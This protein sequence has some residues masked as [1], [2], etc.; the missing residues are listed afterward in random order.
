MIKNIILIGNPNSGKSS[1][2]NRLTGLSQKIGNY[3]GVTVER[4][5]GSSSFEDG[6]SRTI[7]DLP[8]CYSLFPSTQ[9][10][11]IATKEILTSSI[12]STDEIIVYVADIT[13][14]DKHLLLFSQLKSLNKNLILCLNML[15]RANTNIDK[16]EEYFAKTFSVPTVAISAKTGFGIE[17]LKKVIQDFNLPT[18]RESKDIFFDLNHWDEER[19]E[20]VNAVGEKTLLTGREYLNFILT[21]HL[22]WLH[23]ISPAIRDRINGIEQSD[24]KPTQSQ[25]QDTLHRYSILEPIL[26]QAKSHINNHPSISEK[27]DRLV[28]HRIAGPVIFLIL[29]LL[30]FQA[31]FAWAQIPMDWIDGLFG[32]ITE[33]MA[34]SLPQGWFTDLLVNGIVA[35]IGGIV[36]FIPQ[37]AI[38]FLLIG[39]LEETG[40]M[41]RVVFLLDNTMQKLGMNGRS[42]V[43]LVSGG[44]CA[45]PA[46]MSTRT[47]SNWRERLITIMV[48]P[49]I[50]CSARIPVYALLIA[51]VVPYRRVG[52]VFNQQGLAFGLLYFLGA[53]MALIVAFFM[54]KIM[55]GDSR[56]FLM[57]E[58]P[59]YR[60][61]NWKN[62]GI[63]TYNKVKSFVFEAGKIILII[64]I[65]L[66]FLA[67]YGP[68]DSMQAADTLTEQISTE[69]ELSP[70]EEAQTLATLKLEH[71]YAGIMGKAIEPIIRPIGFDWKIGISLIT[72]F[73]AREVFVGTMAT[74]YSVG[75]EDHTASIQEK[76]QKETFLDTGKKVYTKATVWSLLVFYAFA[77]QCMSTLAIVRKETRTWKWPII[78]FVYLTLLA[79][80]SSFIVYTILV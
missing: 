45:I 32:F 20:T 79:Y 44:A 75:S 68:K 33:W 4:K 72:S 53:I 54:K 43:A 18:D 61:P 35:G 23:E 16:V 74:I 77:M 15:D 49:L 7:T 17:K 80:F 24:F 2:F 31:I 66:W 55:K 3:P 67:S 36:I 56:S 69:Q 19:Q 47:I 58:M 48:T 41:A 64:S 39:I 27:L 40:Y 62:V 13:K 51:M 29:M 21:N 12:E 71:S 59:E 73:A 34:T 42:V 8:G 22:D 50:S 11:K 63:A 6:H 14:L 1:V 10:E 78:Q 60:F 9:D 30:I 25:I 38:L 76:M 26:L 46:I 57:L 28:T 65:V 52:G 5:I 70:E 37:I